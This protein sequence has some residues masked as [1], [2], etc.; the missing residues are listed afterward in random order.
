MPQNKRGRDLLPS[1]KAFLKTLPTEYGDNWEDEFR[2]ECKRNEWKDRKY[3]PPLN[4]IID[5]NY[6]C[7]PDP[8]VNEFVRIAYLIEKDP[9]AK[10]ELKDFINAGVEWTNK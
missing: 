3:A 7:D 6:N 8:I 1:E 2:R 5:L 10:Q 4:E 9:S